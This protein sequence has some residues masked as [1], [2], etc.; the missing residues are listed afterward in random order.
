M[1]IQVM[2][3][4]HSGA[5]LGRQAHVHDG[6]GPGQDRLPHHLGRELSGT[7]Q[8]LGDLLRVPGYLLE[9]LVT[10]QM[11]AAG[12]EPEFLRPVLG[13]FRHRT[14]T[15]LWAGPCARRE[16]AQLPPVLHALALERSVHVSRPGWLSL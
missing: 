3:P 9:G 7:I 13:H 4:A 14:L 8:G 6:F 16:A 15:R 10:V 5:V 2:T 1:C 12:E 11:L